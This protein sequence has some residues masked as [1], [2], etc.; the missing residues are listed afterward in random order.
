MPNTENK[1]RRS[2]LATRNVES[3][4]D[5]GFPSRRR[6]LKARAHRASRRLGKALCR[7]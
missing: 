7:P 1:A 4:E 5:W 6:A 3:R 2:I